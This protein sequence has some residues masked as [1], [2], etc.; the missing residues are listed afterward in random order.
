M[1]EVLVNLENFKERIDELKLNKKLIRCIMRQELVS[2]WVAKV[3]FEFSIPKP[4]GILICITPEMFYSK[5]AYD[6]EKL[7]KEEGNETKRI[8]EYMNFYLN[9]FKELFDFEPLE[10]WW[11]E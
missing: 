7:R 11:E 9:K 10:G 5:I 8:K 3:W 6:G 2:D 1:K 4:D